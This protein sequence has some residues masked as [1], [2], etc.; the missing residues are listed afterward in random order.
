MCKSC[1]HS[2]SMSAIFLMNSFYYSRIHLGISVCYFCSIILCRT[3]INN[4]NFYILTAN[5]N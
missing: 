2:L 3:I 1:I 4:Y 5:K